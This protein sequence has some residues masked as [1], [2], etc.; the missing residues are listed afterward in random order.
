MNQIIVSGNLGNDPELRVSTSGVSRVTLNLAIKRY[1]KE[2]FW[3]YF[4]AFGT[5]AENIAKYSK[6]GDKLLI[7]GRIDE[8]T[9]E[10]DGVERSQYQ[11]IASYVEFLSK[12]TETKPKE[13]SDLSSMGL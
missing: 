11:F 10:K 1:E 5:L 2:D 4:T 8:T 7:Q 9:Y 12:K 6:K 3:V 13:E